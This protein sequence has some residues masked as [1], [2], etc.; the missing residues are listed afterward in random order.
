MQIVGKCCESGR[1]NS[2]T[3]VMT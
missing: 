1:F 3:M 2:E